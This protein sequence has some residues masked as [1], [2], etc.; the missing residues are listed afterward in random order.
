MVLGPWVFVAWEVYGSGQLTSGDVLETIMLTF[1]FGTVLS[2]PT[3][4]LYMLASGWLIKGLRSVLV[5]KGAL[6][7]LVIVAVGVTMGILRGSLMPTLF[8]CYSAS[9]ILSSLFIKLPRPTTG[10][11]VEGSGV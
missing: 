4:V 9:V 7:L 3:L 8:G 1:V 5:A 10:P 2:L 11:V 6:N